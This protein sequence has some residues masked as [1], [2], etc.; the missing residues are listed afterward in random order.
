MHKSPKRG[1]HSDNKGERL[2]L[3]I[4]F[5]VKSFAYEKQISKRKGLHFWHEEAN[6]QFISLKTVSYIKVYD[7]VSH[8]KK[9]EYPAYCISKGISGGYRGFLEEGQ[10]RNGSF[11]NQHV[12][13]AFLLPFL[14]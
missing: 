10:R 8:D 9:V 11:Y 6:T 2:Y 14:S 1:L 4:D 7:A 13:E 12:A 5:D 3:N